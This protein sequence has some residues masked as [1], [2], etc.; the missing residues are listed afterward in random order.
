LTP[1]D[2][3]HGLD[4]ERANGSLVAPVEEFARGTVIGSAGVRVPVVAGEELDDA[5]TGML[6]ARDDQRRQ[7]SAGLG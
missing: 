3:V 5:A 1:G 7:S 6:A 4:V 2:C